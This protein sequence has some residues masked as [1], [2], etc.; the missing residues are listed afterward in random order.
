M[1]KIVKRI[2]LIVVLLVAFCICGS[3][4][5]SFKMKEVL[6]LQIENEVYVCELEQLKMKKKVLAE[7]EEERKKQLEDIILCVS[8]KEEMYRQLVNE[9]GK[10]NNK[11]S[12]YADI[13]SEYKQEQLN[14]I[15]IPNFFYDF[16]FAK[17]AAV[18]SNIEG[19]VLDT[20][21]G[22]SFFGA[23]MTDNVKENAIKDDLKL[24]KA[25]F[26]FNIKMENFVSCHTQGIN[27]ILKSKDIIE[28][29]E[30]MTTSFRDTKEKQ[31]NTAYMEKLFGEGLLEGRININ[32]E[33]KIEEMI[34]LYLASEIVTSGYGAMIQD[35]SAYGIWKKYSEQCLEILQH[36]YTNEEIEDLITNKYFEDR[37]Y[38]SD[39]YMDMLNEGCFF[40]IGEGSFKNR[41]KNV[42]V[43]GE[44]N[45]DIRIY[46]KENE[47]K[48]R[49]IFCIKIIDNDKNN[50]VILTYDYKGNVVMVSDEMHDRKYH[51]YNGV[52]L[53]SSCEQSCYQVLEFAE[54]IKEM[55]KDDSKIDK[56]MYEEKRQCF[57]E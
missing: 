37:I 15:Y 18:N 9:Q 39:V 28:F 22:A 35:T 32:I 48:E 19:V 40:V 25:L 11:L 3:F 4:F 56:K 52:L 33:D 29:S 38:L 44:G 43:Q 41:I 7:G 20:L 6:A 36:K 2:V 42:F 13:I 5:Y 50:R 45:R 27:E 31:I 1:I 12:K 57:Y 10:E 23:I 17:E 26:D 16:E 49:Q 14:D 54:W 55:S 24:I 30:I 47:E 8:E 46:Y 21:F 53:N 34:P 51:F